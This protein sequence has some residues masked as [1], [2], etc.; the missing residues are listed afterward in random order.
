MTIFDLLFLLATLGAIASLGVAAYRAVRGQRQR[1]V[2]IVQWVAAGIAIYFAVIIAVSLTTPQ[3]IVPTGVPQ[4]FDDWCIKVFAVDRAGDSLHVTVDLSSR[5]RRIS[6]GER[7]V[8]IHVVDADGE[9]YLPIEEPG[10]VPLSVT[11]PPEGKVRIRRSFAIPSGAR[12]LKLLV[13]HDAFPHCCIIGDR[14]SLLRR[15]AV[16]LLQ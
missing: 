2:I 5:A 9:R 14:E 13:A 7:D 4:C 11:I 10:A 8:R 12:D 3:P 6:Q 16:V 1:A 15:P